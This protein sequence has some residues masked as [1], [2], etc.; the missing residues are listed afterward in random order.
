MI[1]ISACDALSIFLSAIAF[2]NACDFHL[3]ISSIAL[4]F[5]FFHIVSSKLLLS[6]NS[7]ALSKE[8]LLEFR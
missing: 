2:K 5:S 7:L 3:N 8:K 1:F 6:E 4:A